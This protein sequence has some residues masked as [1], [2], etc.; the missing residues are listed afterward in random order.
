MRLLLGSVVLV[1]SACSNNMSSASSVTK[2]EGARRVSDTIDTS[3]D[4]G[5]RRVFD[6]IDT[7][8][9]GQ[10]S[11]QEWADLE[12]RMTASVPEDQR[13]RYVGALEAEFKT[14]DSNGDGNVTFTEFQANRLTTPPCDRCTPVTPG[15]VP[16]TP[17]R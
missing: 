8:K 3:K 9:D 5:A 7:S 15:W 14:L 2:D 10:I 11:H 1:C 13:Q 17:P 6:A 16:L 4:E 12:S